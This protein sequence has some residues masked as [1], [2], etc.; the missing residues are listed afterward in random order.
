M[1]SKWHQDLI[2]IKFLLKTV[3]KIGNSSRVSIINELVLIKKNLPM[4]AQYRDQM[5]LIPKKPCTETDIWIVNLIS[6]THNVPL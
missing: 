1:W 4:H 2:G 3:D 5:I 6:T